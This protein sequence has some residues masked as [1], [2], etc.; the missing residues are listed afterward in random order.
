MFRAVPKSIFLVLLSTV[1]YSSLTAQ[2]LAVSGKVQSSLTGEGLPYASI[3]LDGT[4][5]G[6]TSNIEGQ[7]ILTLTSQQ[8]SGTLVISSLGFA[9]VRI[10]VTSALQ[11]GTILLKPAAVMLREVEVRAE[12]QTLIEAAVAA[13]PRN[14]DNEAIIMKVFTRA[15]SKR[16]DYP[17]QASEAAFEMYRGKIQTKSK[18]NVREVRILRGRISRDSLAFRK[19]HQVNIGFTPTALFML[20]MARE[21]S[22]LHDPKK[23]DKH[24]FTLRGIITYNDRPAY[25][26]EFD[27][28]D[29]LKE[30]G[31]QG[32]IY[33][34]TATLA[35]MHIE[36]GWSKKGLHYLTETFENKAAAKI[37][38]LHKSRWNYRDLVVDYSLNNGKWY[39]QRATM[40]GSFQ[41]IREKEGL[42]T[43]LIMDD[44]FLVTEV[45][46]DKVVPFPDDEVARRHQHIEKQFEAYDAEFWKGYNYQLPD[47]GFKEIFE[48]I[49]HRNEASRA[50]RAPENKRTKRNRS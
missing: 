49:Q 26:I 12:K 17:I 45:V 16:E 42:N 14:Y 39:L 46:K 7:Y 44:L 21:S 25:K 31:H 22:L 8:Q 41:L 2:S 9:T 33:I 1:L 29:S 37:L 36:M 38:G 23:R 47:P 18:N 30:S 10:P 32:L 19:I 3:S 4:T 50:T 28:K 35:F 34:D 48:E 43:A 15:L 6:T 13:V 40:K 27:Q 11:S 24:I 5:L 20:D